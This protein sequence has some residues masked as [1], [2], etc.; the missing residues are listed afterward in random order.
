[1][2]YCLY[3][4]SEGLTIIQEPSRR[5]GDFP[6]A[7]RFLYNK[8]VIRPLLLLGGGRRFFGVDESGGGC[9]NEV[10]P[11]IWNDVLSQV[12]QQR[13]GRLESTIFGLSR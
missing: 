7:R 8:S 13:L 5:I 11:I 10:S 6:V 12:P 9:F 4:S 2:L 1:M 3:P